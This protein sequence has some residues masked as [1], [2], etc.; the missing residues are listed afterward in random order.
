[1]STDAWLLLAAV[2]FDLVLGDPHGMPHPVRAF[3]TAVTQLET[4]WRKAAR[5]CGLRVSG[6]LFTLTAVCLAGA[7]VWLSLQL[8]SRWSWLAAAVTVYWIYALLAVRSLDLESWAVIEQLERN[9]IDAGRRQL[10]M[11]VG[12]DTGNL[13]E[14]EVLRGV[15]E[16]VAENLTDAVVAPLFYFA[17]AGPVGM[18]VYKAAN[19]LDSMTGYKNEQYRE[20]GWAS[21][22]LDD[23]LNFVP[24][25][26]TVVLVALVALVMRLHAGRALATAWRDAR[27]QPSPNSGYP[28]AAVAGALGVQLGGLNFYGGKPSAK[29]LIGESL[30][31]LSAQICGRARGL[32]YGTA[33][34]SVALTMWVIA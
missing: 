20:F 24:A 12:R 15:V 10:A 7:F 29:P 9:G 19:T 27:L 5:V 14:Q 18:A 22:R 21:A 30:V 4:A 28:E 3:G 1:M 17:L 23:L 32:L 33:M 34:L 31:P 2:G 11:I 25:R 16:T 13:D 26:L 8:A 6:I